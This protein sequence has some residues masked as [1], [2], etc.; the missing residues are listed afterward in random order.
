MSNTHEF[1]SRHEASDYLVTRWGIRRTPKTLAK[2]ATIGGG[3]AYR[4]DGRLVLYAVADLDEWAR[5]RLAPSYTST[6]EY[7]RPAA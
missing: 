4:K 5:A 7:P 3:P 2:L 1:Y 6:S